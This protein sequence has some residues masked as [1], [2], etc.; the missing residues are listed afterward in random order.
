[1]CECVLSY[2]VP[3]RRMVQGGRGCSWTGARC[4]PCDACSKRIESYLK[5]QL[6]ETSTD[7]YD[8]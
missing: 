3:T 4:A 2:Y 8:Y 5:D 1:M 7:P 6:D